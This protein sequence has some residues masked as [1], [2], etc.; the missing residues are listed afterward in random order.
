MRILKKI[1]RKILPKAA[2]SKNHSSDELSRLAARAREFKSVLHAIK[3]QHPLPSNR[4]F[5]YPYSTLDNFIEIEK[6]LTGTNRNLFCKVLSEPVADVGGA[7]GDICYFLEKQGFKRLQLIENRN[8]N[9]SRLAG[10]KTLKKVLRSGVDICDIDIDTDFRLPQKR[11]GLILFLG[12]LY[13]LRN[14]MLALQILAQQGRYCL[15]STRVASR[16]PGLSPKADAAPLAYLL[17]K[18]ELNNDSSNYWIFT[19]EG[20]RRM[21]TRCGWNVVDFAVCGNIGK[22]YPASLEGCERAFCLLESGY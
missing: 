19:P 5:W 2:G 20:L 12:I 21:L 17:D 1:A 16:I 14:P 8:L 9:C 4:G 6:T 15:I 10:A 22:S 11:Y 13:H 7:D 3:T 18:T